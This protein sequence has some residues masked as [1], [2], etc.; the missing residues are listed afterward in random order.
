MSPRRHFTVTI[1]KNNSTV[2]EEADVVA[3][4]PA[5]AARLAFK[6][7]LSDNN[8]NLNDNLTR[9]AMVHEINSRTKEPLER[10]DFWYTLNRTYVPNEIAV[11]GVGFRSN[12]KYTA[13]AI[14]QKK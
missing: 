14:K 9:E 11:A 4:T 3:K 12:Y 2:S 8:N 1:K 6:R 7:Y 13:H 10:K 5:R